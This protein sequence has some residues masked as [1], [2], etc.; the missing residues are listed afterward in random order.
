MCKIPG[1]T[2]TVLDLAER[3]VKTT[4]D[5]GTNKGQHGSQASRDG[6]FVWVT[7]E[8]PQSLLEIDAASGKIVNQWPTKQERSHLMVVTPDEKK[9]YVTNTVSGSVTVIDRSTGNAKVIPI[10]K[11]AEAIT[12]SPDGGEVWVGM[13]VDNKIV[14]ISTAKDAI[15]E[16]IESGG[17]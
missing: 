4:Y 11:G 16:T 1:N 5:Y 17:K 14:V 12:I 7:S 2:I 9:F 15:V 3:K 13:P 10:G 8:T 6:K